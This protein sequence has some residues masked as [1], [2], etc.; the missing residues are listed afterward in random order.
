M[1]TFQDKQAIGSAILQNSEIPLSAIWSN[2]TAI[3]IEFNE[4]ILDAMPDAKEYYE[5]R[6]EQLIPFDIPI[7]VEEPYRWGLENED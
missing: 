3:L 1:L 5:A 7:I 4:A 6:A 2:N